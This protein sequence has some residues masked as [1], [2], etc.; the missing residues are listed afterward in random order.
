MRKSII[1]G[2]MLLM[3]ATSVEAASI[4]IGL[5][6]SDIYTMPNVAPTASMK[7]TGGTV[8]VPNR[9][10]RF[11]FEGEL[12]HWDILVADQNGK[13]DISSVMMNGTACAVTTSLATGA[14]L[15]GY[16][17]SGTFDPNIMAIY[18]CD[19]AAS[20]AHGN[21]GFRAVAADLSGST[22]QTA[23]DT[24]L[25]NPSLAVSTDSALQFGALGP[26]QQ[27][28]KTLKF[29]NIGEV[30]VILGISA[31]Q[32]FYDPSSSGA[33]CP[34]TNALSTQ[35]DGALFTTG[36]WYSAVSGS[37]STGNKRI[38]VGNTFAQS[39]Q[40]I[41]NVPLSAGASMS[42]TFHLGLPIP[43]QGHFTNGQIYLWGSVV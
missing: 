5:I 2:L 22:G 33:I 43:C 9:V 42:V 14:S 30:P 21:S 11:A 32:N 12:L 18:A 13:S 31:D 39:G 16:G 4:R 37:V 34:T 36:F 10:G 17:L 1:V 15:S 38:P 3:L 41:G 8:N 6:G 29:T 19:L 25:L 40:I 28:A 23:A 24:W 26:G 35:G 27:A 20:S 7:L